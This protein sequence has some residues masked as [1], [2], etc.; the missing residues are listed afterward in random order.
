MT[1]DVGPFKRTP[2]K[3]CTKVKTCRHTNTL[4]GISQYHQTG[5]NEQDFPLLSHV[6]RCN[7]DRKLRQTKA[8]RLPLETDKPARL[9][10][11]K[12]RLSKAML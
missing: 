2:A 9:V 3:V 8:F 4:T 6:F 11:I 10:S 1:K 7:D 12:T 5:S